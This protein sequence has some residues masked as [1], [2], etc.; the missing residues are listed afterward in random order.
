M[1]VHKLMSGIILIFFGLGKVKS[2]LLILRQIVLCRF[3]VIYLMLTGRASQCFK[4]RRILWCNRS[5]SW[6]TGWGGCFGKTVWLLA[7]RGDHNPNLQVAITSLWHVCSQLRLDFHQEW[8][9]CTE[10]NLVVCIW[11]FYHS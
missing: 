2:H 4:W 6:S 9:K 10:R 5:S 7:T 1:N 8:I 3:V 11:T